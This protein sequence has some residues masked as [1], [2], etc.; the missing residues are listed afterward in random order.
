[1]HV[2]CGVRRGGKWRFRENPITNIGFILAGVKP[3]L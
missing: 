2:P 1:M 3:M